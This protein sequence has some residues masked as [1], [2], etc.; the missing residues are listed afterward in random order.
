MLNVERILCPVDFSE[1]SDRACDYAHSFARHFGAKLFVLHVAEPFVPIHHSYISPSLIDQIYA[2]QIADAEEKVR[3]LAARQNWND[4]EHEVVLERGA[5]ADAILQFVEGKNIDL[6][7]MGTH[8]RRGLDRLVL[9]SA[10]ERILRTARPPVLAVHSPLQGSGTREEPVQFRNILFC[11]DFSDNSPRALEYA[12][13]LACKY[14]AGI[15]LL[16]VIERSD[17]G[18]DLEAEKRQ[19][20]Q[21]LQAVVPQNVQNCAAAEPAV[22]AG[23]TYQ[24]ILEHAAET[25]TDLIVMGV[26]GR[27]ALDLALFGSTTQRVIQLGQWPVLVVRT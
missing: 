22:R 14:K 15:S 26:R 13:L 3:K 27:N 21:Q 5:V 8:G 25:R 6:I 10:T 2:Q 12:F 11:T 4:V 9:G 18:K 24:E 17:G 7:A 16:H 1:F 20:L 19:A 23:K